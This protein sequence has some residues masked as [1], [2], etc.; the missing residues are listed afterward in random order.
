MDRH[1]Y[2]GQTHKQPIRKHNTPPLTCGW[3]QKQINMYGIKQS[4]KALYIFNRQQIYVTF[5]AL[6]KK[7]QA[8]IYKCR[9]MIWLYTHKHVHIVITSLFKI[10]YYL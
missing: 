9:Y 1:M 5:L 2:D 10:P 4:K 6:A 8:F 7:K 3:T